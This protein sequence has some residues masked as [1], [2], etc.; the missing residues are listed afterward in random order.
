M[1]I[2]NAANAYVH[3]RDNYPI[4]FIEALEGNVL[5]DVIDKGFGNSP[6]KPTQR[7]LNNTYPIFGTSSSEQSG[8][9]FRYMRFWIDKG[10]FKT[11]TEQ[12]PSLQKALD[13]LDEAL[14]TAPRLTCRLE[15]GEII[16]CHNW[17]TPHD[18]DEYDE[19]P[20]TPKR[21]MVRI[22]LE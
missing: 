1:K 15:R 3:L 17:I 8:F 2:T 6:T 13:Y 7:L 18:R 12:S 21:H 20:G 19:P 11:N 14:N 16:F 4:K 5:R 9:Q 22:W 10:Y